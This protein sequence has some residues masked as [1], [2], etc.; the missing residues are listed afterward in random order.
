MVPRT[1]NK[2]RTIDTQ[3][4]TSATLQQAP[5]LKMRCLLEIWT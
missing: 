1:S 5:H 2:R 4:R 3:I